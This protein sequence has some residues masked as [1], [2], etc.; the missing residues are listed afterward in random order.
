MNQVI[1][2]ITQ[3]LKQN[4]TTINM[5]LLS[6]TLLFLF[7]LEH[8]LPYDIKGRVE[9]ELKILLDNVWVRVLLS[10][11]IFAIFQ[12]GNVNMLV[13]VLYLIHHVSLHQ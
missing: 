5:V 12:A 7:P 10:L 9:T 11:L 8:F 4:S 6:L 2:P 13:L 1:S 3:V